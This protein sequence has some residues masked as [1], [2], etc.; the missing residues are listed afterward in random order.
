MI[1]R[2]IA[3]SILWLIS[4]M[5]FA[6]IEPINQ[7]TTLTDIDFFVADTKGQ[8]RREDRDD[9]QDDRKDCRK[10]EGRVGGDKRDCKQDN[11][12]DGDDDA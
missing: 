7:S 11:R 9:N 1:T 3:A 12:R 6:D 8:D 5:A 2:S 10:D 4:C